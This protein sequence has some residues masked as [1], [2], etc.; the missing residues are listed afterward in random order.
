MSKRIGYVKSKPVTRRKKTAGVEGLPRWVHFAL[1]PIYPFLFVVLSQCLALGDWVAGFAFPFQ[2]PFL[3]LA[4]V[5]LVSMIIALLFGLTN[6]RWVAFSLTNFIG[7]F[8][9]F[10]SNI[11]LSILGT[12]LEGG[13][14]GVFKEEN[15]LSRVSA[16][17]TIIPFI[18][19][20]ILFSLIL[21]GCIF[22]MENFHLDKKARLTLIIASVLVFLIFFKGIL[23][24]YMG[25]RTEKKSINNIGVYIYFCGYSSKKSTITYPNE[26]EVFK[27]AQLG[28]IPERKSEITPNVI[29]LEIDNFWDFNGANKDKVG[30]NPLVK[31]QE[32]LTEAKYLELS[33]S[34]NNES[35]LNG[36]Y[37]ALVGLPSNLFIEDVQVNGYNIVDPMISLASILSKSGYQCSSISSF[38]SN[39]NQ[40]ETFYQNLGFANFYGQ[41]YFAET[42]AKA[43]S[44]VNDQDVINKVGSILGNEDTGNKFIYAHLTSLDKSYDKGNADD[45]LADYKEGLGKI[46]AYLGQLEEVIEASAKPTIIV[47]Y[48]NNLPVLGK[49]N[50]LYKTLEYV[51]T[52]KI[53]D[54]DARVKLETVPGFIWN[55]YKI[56]NDTMQTE[57]LDL[58]FLPERI[59]TLSDFKMPNYFHFIK[60][61]REKEGIEA[62]SDEYLIKK[63]VIYDKTSDYYKTIRGRYEIINKDILGPHKYL[64]AGGQEWLVDI[65]E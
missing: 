28:D 60:N 37:E 20:L 16:G 59:L 49:S 4:T 63:G 38:K 40:R 58:S 47:F 34:V 13:E 61:L 18:F 41:E 55:N 54:K 21:Y 23:P 46:D 29:Y 6:N 43:G 62:F 7:F 57:K 5:L 1:W 33:T 3:Y 56:Q 48:S 39:N 8:I 25:G 51:T 31:Y 17:G 11:K 36:E 26:E 50:S 9:A 42:L 19:S 24:A 44:E 14:L 15:I 30:S 32:I 22:F 27:A 65:E 64:E 10:W 52:T 12:G 45:N 53:S 2:E 35:N